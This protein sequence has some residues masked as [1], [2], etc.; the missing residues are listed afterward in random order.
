MITCTLIDAAKRNWTGKTNLNT[1]KKRAYGNVNEPEERLEGRSQNVGNGFRDAVGKECNYRPT[2]VGVAPGPPRRRRNPLP[3]NDLR[4]SRTNVVGFEAHCVLICK[5]I[6][7]S[8]HIILKPCSYLSACG[9]LSLLSCCLAVLQ[10]GIV[11]SMSG[12]LADTPC[13]NRVW[14]IT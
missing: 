1:T 9:D 12:H 11:C 6:T 5:H 3:P 13:R 10:G 14:N 4:R 7:T 8:V 2:P